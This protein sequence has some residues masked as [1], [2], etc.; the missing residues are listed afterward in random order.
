M[1]AGAQVVTDDVR[2]LVRAEVGGTA[3]FADL[4]HRFYLQVAADGLLTEL[5]PDIARAERILALY[6]DEFWLGPPGYTSERGHPRMPM[7]HM[8][9]LIGTAQTRSWLR[10][11][12]T[13]IDQQS[14]GA[15]VSGEL[16]RWFAGLARHIVEALE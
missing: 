6:L 5:Y 2:R 12:N 8:P 1:T 13:A 14:L 7:R 10:A 9:F 3:G 15:E 11:M 4:S 16:K